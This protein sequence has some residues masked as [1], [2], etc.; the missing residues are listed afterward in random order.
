MMTKDEYQRF[1]EEFAG[2]W[3][4]EKSLKSTLKEYIATVKDY[5]KFITERGLWVEFRKYLAA[6]H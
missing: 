3:Q 1:A 6:K 4:S 2:T 5:E